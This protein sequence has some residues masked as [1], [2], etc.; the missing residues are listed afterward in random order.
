[1]YKINP[2]GR[3]FTLGILGKGNVFGELDSFSL[4]LSKILLNVSLIQIPTEGIIN[5]NRTLT[6]KSHRNLA[7]YLRPYWKC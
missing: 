5:K 3:Q 7:D 1:M 2:D 6:L 4:D